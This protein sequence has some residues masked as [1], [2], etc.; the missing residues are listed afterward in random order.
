MHMITQPLL[1]QL[2]RND[3]NVPKT[4]V[5]AGTFSTAMQIVAGFAGGVALLLIVIAGLKYVLAQGNPQETAK[6]K[7]TILYALVGLVVSVSAYSIIAFV[8]SKV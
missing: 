4:D 6:A 1:A 8:I 3:F 5:T 2:T 7:N